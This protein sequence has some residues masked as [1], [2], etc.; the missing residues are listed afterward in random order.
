V[1]SDKIEEA[2]DCL[3]DM[4]FLDGV[5]PSIQHFQIPLDHISQHGDYELGVK[6]LKRMREVGL[7]PSQREWA[8][9]LSAALVDQDL[10]RIPMA[11]DQ[12]KR[13][14]NL[15]SPGIDF[16]N[17]TLLYINFYIFYSNQFK[18]IDINLFKKVIMY[19][20]QKKDAGDKLILLFDQLI[21]NNLMS[22]K[23]KEEILEFLEKYEIYEVVY[24]YF[25]KK[26]TF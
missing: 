11:I 9:M 20:T 21:E 5:I 12:M 8:A 2:V 19:H 3:Y 17:I 25:S 23:L 1:S 24:D 14:D 10:D 15:R 16:L 13:L 26:I 18:K 7:K 22:K 4:T 6:C